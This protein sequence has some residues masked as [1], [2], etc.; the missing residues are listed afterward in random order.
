M[1]DDR[2]DMFR[3]RY[4]DGDTPWDSGITPPEIMQILKE[5]PAGA[6]LDLG[7]GTGT[8]MRDLLASGWRVDGVDFV[9]AAIDIARRKLSD[10]Q[11]E[12]WRLFCHDVTRLDDLPQLRSGYHLIIDIGCGHGLQGAAAQNYARGV[13]S[14]LATNGAFMLYAAQPREGASMGWTP[15]YV[16]RLFCRSL[17]LVWRQD[18]E[19]SKIGAKSS[20]YRLGKVSEPC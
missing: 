4:A 9:P 15:A 3:R 2:R 8:V 7:C 13:S 6:A 12:R 14:R 20:W 19:D 1:T 5:L 11:P 17:G 10:C 16:E 18:G